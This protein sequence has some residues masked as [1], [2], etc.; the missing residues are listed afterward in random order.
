MVLETFDD[1]VDFVGFGVWLAI[2]VGPG[3][4]LDFVCFEED[5]GV[6]FS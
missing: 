1:L 6:D 5:R 3:L 2:E 4:D